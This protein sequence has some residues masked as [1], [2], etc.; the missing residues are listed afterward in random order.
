MGI[1][2]AMNEEAFRIGKEAGCS[3]VTVVATGAKSQKL[4]EKL[5]FQA[6]KK[7]KYTEYFFQGKAA[8]SGY[9]DGLGTDSINLY[10]RKL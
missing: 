7:L 9:D 1:A 6:L 10:V 2:Q 8:F 5:G 4:F 3:H